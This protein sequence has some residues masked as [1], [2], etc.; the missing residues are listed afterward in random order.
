[1]TISSCPVTPPPAVV[2]VI[3]VIVVARVA[4]A[5]GRVDGLHG[6]L[7]PGFGRGVESLRAGVVL[8]PELHGGLHGDLRLLGKAVA[9]VGGRRAVAWR[10]RVVRGEPRAVGWRSAVATPV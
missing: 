2:I 1:M 7:R 5:W 6:D 9:A 3:G 8:G 10:R 4:P